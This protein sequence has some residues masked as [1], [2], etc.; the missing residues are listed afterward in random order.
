MDAYVADKVRDWFDEQFHLVKGKYPDGPGYYPH[1]KEVDK[2]AS[3]LRLKF[4][5]PEG[6]T[7]Q[8]V[9]FGPYVKPVLGSGH[10]F[11]INN[12]ILNMV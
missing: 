2:W 7:S 3:E 12:L 6:K 4:N 1:G 5:V 11:Y 8:D 9:V 10:D